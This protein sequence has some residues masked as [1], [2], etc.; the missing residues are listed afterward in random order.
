MYKNVNQKKMTNFYS[1]LNHYLF[2]KIERK[3]FDTKITALIF[4]SLFL[5]SIHIF[6]Q[7][8][9]EITDVIPINITRLKAVVI[10]ESVLIAGSMTALY[11]L[12]Y[13]NYP[14]NGFHFVNDNREWLQMDKMGHTLTSYY[15]GKI[16]YSA[17]KW[18]GV[19]ES[20]AIWYGGGVGSV[21]LLTIE[22]LDGFSKE[23]GFSPGDFAANTL[24]SAL[25]I[26]Q[27]LAWHEQRILLKYSA[28]TTDFAQYRPDLLGENLPQRILKDYNGCTIWLS[29]NVY[30]FL[31]KSSVF[32]KWL[33]IAFGY[34]AEGMTGG[35]V[36]PE[37]YNAKVL[38]RFDRYRQFYLSLD[39]DLT[40]IPTKSKT[41]ALIFDLLGFIKI[42]LPTLEYNT[43][44]GFKA[45]PLYF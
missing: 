22:I 10:S 11:T 15:F 34:G 28:H 43:K 8:S 31:P 19:K 14:M 7:S 40:H 23:W 4:V 27:Q 37:V 20:K 44:D 36:N 29:G 26:S 38:P 13:K 42:P 30:S 12:W 39:I 35:Y 1:K 24:G 5:N 16:G 21:Y 17:L 45:H 32:P 2:S 9:S 3:V 33:N 41:L 6:A 18:S 25:F